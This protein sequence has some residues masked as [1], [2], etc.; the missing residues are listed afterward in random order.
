MTAFLTALGYAEAPTGR[1][2]GSRRRFA[3]PEAAAIVLHKPH[4]QDI[5]KR[6]AIDQVLSKLEDEGLL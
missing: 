4:P 2:G 6:Y 5:V 1:S 3:H